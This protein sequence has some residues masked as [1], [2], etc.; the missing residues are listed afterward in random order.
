ML[1]IDDKELDK[2]I[3]RVDSPTYKSKIKKNTLN[4]NHF[5]NKII[6]DDYYYTNLLNGIAKNNFIYAQINNGSIDKSDFSNSYFVL[7]TINGT[8]IINSN[9][10]DAN[11]SQADLTKAYIDEDSKKHIDLDL[12]ETPYNDVP[13]L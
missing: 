9:F 6:K 10:K 2:F 11:F 4:M 5:E 13:S 1:P 3:K 7:S 8:K 12:K